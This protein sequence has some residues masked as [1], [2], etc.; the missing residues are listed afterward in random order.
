M[1]KLS[2]AAILAIT[3]IGSISLVQA[4]DL[5]I[6]GNIGAT[7]NYVWRGMTQTNDKSSVN[8]GV[9]LGYNG[10]YVGTWASNVDFLDETNYELD[11]YAGYS[12]L[13]GDFSY[14]VSYI[15]YLFP[16]SNPSSNS[17]EATIA[18]GYDINAL[19]L[20]VSYA[21]STYVENNGVKN[22]YTELTASYDFEILSLDTSF[23]DYENT[24]SNYTV[25][26]S[27]SF[28]LEGN[29]LDLALVYA[30]FDA[31]AGPSGDEENVYTTIT[32]S[33]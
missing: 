28:E 14:D 3:T 18:L 11:I 2:L 33:F 16:G 25:G 24:G 22:D 29:S 7:S 19:S 13:I 8:G 21:F 27:K 5:E 6:S 31:D 10:F 23:G 32:Y 26:I 1:K 4:D 17:D 20:G 12:N 15:K 9:D 30:S